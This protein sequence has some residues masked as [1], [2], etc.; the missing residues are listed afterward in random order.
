MWQQPVFGSCTTYLSDHHRW[1]LRR[2]DNVGKSNFALI[3][4]TD[5]CCYHANISCLINNP[6][7]KAK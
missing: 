7:N 6:K 3:E 4:I 1:H 2:N 5:F